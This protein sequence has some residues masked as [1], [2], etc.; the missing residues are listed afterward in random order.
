MPTAARNVFL[1]HDPRPDHIARQ[2]DLLAKV[3]L[4]TGTAVAI[5]HPHTATLQTLRRKL[6]ELKT[7]NIVVVAPSLIVD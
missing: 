5:G 3:A 2:F 6:P 7:K 4:R 1:D